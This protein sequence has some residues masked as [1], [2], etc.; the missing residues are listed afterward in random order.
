MIETPLSSEG[1]DERRR[2]ALFRA[3]HRGLR[4]MDLLLGRFADAH[5]ARLSEGELADFERLMDAPDVEVFSWLTGA[6]TI[7]SNFATPLFEKL[8]LFH[9]HHGP[10]PL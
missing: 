6:E 10:L 5:L 8:K 2:R 4:E 9:T 3:R 1:L 7:P